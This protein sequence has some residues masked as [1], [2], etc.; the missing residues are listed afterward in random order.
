MRNWKRVTWMVGA[1]VAATAATAGIALAVV[2][3]A[4]EQ[5][6]DTVVQP[7]T[8][9]QVEAL[10]VSAPTSTAAAPASTDAG[11]TTSSSTAPADPDPSTTTTTVP[12][13][14]STVPDGTSTTAVATT[15]TS[16]AP[17]TTTTTEAA[18][19]QVDSRHITGG[20]VVVRWT[21][22]SVELVSASPDD[23]YKVDIE[24]R[25]PSAVEVEFE[26]DGAKSTYHAEISDG[27]LAV[28]TSV[29][30]DD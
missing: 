24:K 19:S 15:T 13:S 8:S 30:D 10:G 29:E 2:N 12:E 20:T 9:E 3:L 14:T 5:V 6:A 18:S 22:T 27:Q 7:L 1:W 23:G 11:T 4:G 17:S 26:G 28:Q 16:A 25:G 21:P